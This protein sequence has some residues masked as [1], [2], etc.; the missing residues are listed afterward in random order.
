MMFAFA[1]TPT[2]QVWLEGIVGCQSVSEWASD[3]RTQTLEFSPA[4]FCFNQQ[5]QQ[6]HHQH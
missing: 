4:C 3:F 2:T 1:Y 5:R 6:H